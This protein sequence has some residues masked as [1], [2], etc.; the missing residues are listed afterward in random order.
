M[1]SAVL[2]HWL[3]TWVCVAV[4]LPWVKYLFG[5]MP[6]AMVGMARPL[7]FVLVGVGVWN[8]AMIGLVPF[9]AG[10]VLFVALV[11]GVIGWRLAGGIDKEWV[12]A[13]WRTWVLSEI[14]FLIAMALVVFI[15]SRNADP[16][17]TERPMDYAFFNSVMH[18]P[19]FPPLDP[20]MSGFTINY[21]YAGYIL[22][23]IPA[24]ITAADPVVSYNLALAT[25]AGM[26]AAAVVSIVIAVITQW[27]PS[28]RALGRGEAPLMATLAFAALLLVGNLGG[29]L[30][31]VTGVPEVL[32]LESTDINHAIQNGLG[33]RGTLQLAKPFKGWDFDGNTSF[34]PRDT[35]ADFNWWNPS[36]SVWDTTPVEDGSTE[37]R[38]AITEFPFF[39]FWL[40]DMHPHVMALPFVLLLMAL[41]MRRANGKTPDLLIPALMLGLLYPLNSWDYPTY[42][43]L[44]VGAII[45]YGV[46]NEVSW[47]DIAREIGIVAIAS[48]AWYLPFHVSFHSLVGAAAPLV[49]VPVIG[50][51]SRYFGAAPARTEFHGLFIMFG[52][53]F[54]PILIAMARMITTKQE[55]I[56]FATTI[57]VGVVGVFTGFASIAAVPLAVLALYMIFMRSDIP[58][59][60][61]IW[62]GM[63]AI[64]ALLCCAVD[65]VYVR[66]VFSSRMNTVFKFY[67]QVWTIWSLSS[68]VAGWYVWQVGQRWWRLGL[69]VVTIPILIA[70][71]FYPAVTVG[72]ALFVDQTGDLAG[73][74][75]RDNPEGGHDSIVWLRNNA[76]AG[77]V[78]VE[79]VGGQYDTEG[80][81]FGGVSAST[82]LPAVMGWPGHED[83][84]RGGHLEAKNQIGA[85]DEDVRTIYSSGEE[86]VV[87]P[88]LAKY[89]VRYVY[90][91]PTERDV[92]GEGG[93]VLFD[94]IATVA[95]QQGQITIF[96]IKK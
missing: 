53:F 83:Q 7:G 77:S 16:W 27:R 64:A 80:K 55:R 46:R 45:W 66:D 72:K 15:R 29:F 26:S 49:N 38:Y 76:P 28:G 87:Q 43:V 37:R 60:M 70:A 42:M 18:S 89:H 19:S 95:F 41:A 25:T 85:R 61:V 73:K 51:L 44:Y 96:E 22:A 68:V 39:S 24:L 47:Q 21:Y 50:A 14:F 79:A 56:L 65:V 91:G 81:G 71:L 75:P 84:W 78:I 32:A 11:I 2:L 30:Q 9:N 59:M 31:I 63:T 6:T 40:G 88:L 35:W 17:G 1:F 36:R 57:V 4:G 5:A 86:A 69:C 82:G 74:T 48:Y 20:W 62:L 92:Y 33:N 90:V 93:L 54:V 23:A 58:P 67:Y 10:S 94:S 8:C 3:A 12:R 13:H 52:L 34:T